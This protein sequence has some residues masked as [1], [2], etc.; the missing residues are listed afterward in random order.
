MCATLWQFS[1]GLP[2]LQMQVVPFRVRLGRVLET[3]Y[4]EDLAVLVEV[5]LSRGSASGSVSSKRATRSPHQ[6]LYIHSNSHKR[7]RHFPRLY[8][9]VQ[10]LCR[11]RLR[12]SGSR[13]Q[14]HIPVVEY[15]VMWLDVSMS[16]RT[17]PARQLDWSSN[18]LV[19]VKLAG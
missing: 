12:V 1:N 5:S 8:I 9:A 2:T 16:D 6:C 15:A 4:Q 14:Q 3:R 17:W 10:A 18:K 7:I 11:R 19:A 13:L